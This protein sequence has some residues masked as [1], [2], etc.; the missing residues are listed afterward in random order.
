[1]VVNYALV[2]MW[3]EGVRAYFKVLFQPVETEE[4]QKRK[5]C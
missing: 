3:K 2:N 4:N 1:M 5:K